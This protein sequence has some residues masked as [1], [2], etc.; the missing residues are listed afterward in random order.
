PAAASAQR[1]ELAGRRFQALGVSVV[2][3]PRNPYVP[4]TH[5]NVRF[6]FAEQ[7][8]KSSVWWFGGGFDLTPYYGFEEDAHHWHATARTACEPFGHEVYPQLKAW[9]DRYFLLPHRNE[10][11]G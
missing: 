8:G 1:P 5:M 9:C 6:F 7:P 11:R 3:H 4:T 10:P 2:G